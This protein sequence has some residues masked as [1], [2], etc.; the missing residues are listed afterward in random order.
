MH[1]FDCW[2]AL[3]TNLILHSILHLSIGPSTEK[4]VWTPLK[5]I[6]LKRNDQKQNPFE[7]N[8]SYSIY[9]PLLIHPFADGIQ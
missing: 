8:F 2:M 6:S 3:T 1:P 9:H 4:K 5:E 7:T